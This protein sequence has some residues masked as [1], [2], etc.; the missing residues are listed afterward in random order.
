[1]TVKTS[2]SQILGQVRDFLSVI[3]CLVNRYSKTEV[4]SISVKGQMIN[5]KADYI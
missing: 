1:M 2:F 4:I 3:Y 5:I